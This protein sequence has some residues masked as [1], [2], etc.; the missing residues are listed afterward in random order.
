MEDDNKGECLESCSPG[1]RSSLSTFQVLRDWMVS[2]AFYPFNP[3]VMTS[4]TVLT[5]VF[6]G[7]LTWR[8]ISIDSIA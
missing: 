5:V 1:S 8:K 3:K 2:I 6:G 7:I 4:E